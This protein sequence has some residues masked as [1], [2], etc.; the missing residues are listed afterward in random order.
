MI[1]DYYHSNRL[2]FTLA[3]LIFTFTSKEMKEMLT[4]TRLCYKILLNNM[5]FIDYFVI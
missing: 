3:R 2:Q 4:E 5:K 1:I